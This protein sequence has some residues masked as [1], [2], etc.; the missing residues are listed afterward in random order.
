MDDY[1]VRVII[2][3]PQNNPD[4][5]TELATAWTDEPLYSIGAEIEAQAWRTYRQHISNLANE[6]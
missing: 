6:Q 5:T 1:R 4:V 3:D 2:Y